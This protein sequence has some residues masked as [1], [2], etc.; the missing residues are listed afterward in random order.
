M[1]SSGILTAA[2]MAVAF[3]AGCNSVPMADAPAN[4][5]LSSGA[6]G[7]GYALM[8]NGDFVRIDEHG[9]AQSTCY[10]CDIQ[11]GEGECAATAK[12]RGVPVCTPP[13]ANVGDV[14]RGTL[15]CQ[16]YGP[17]GPQPPVPFGTP[18]YQCVLYSPTFCIC[19]QW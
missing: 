6:H 4:G 1:R 16:A 15:M 8:K 18:G 13:D 5:Y 11:A 10:M 14:P 17:T 3:L 9:R 7:G 12:A 2:L 19:Y